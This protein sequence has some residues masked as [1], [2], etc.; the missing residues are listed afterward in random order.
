[1]KKKQSNLFNSIN[2]NVLDYILSFFKKTLIN[3]EIPKENN[4]LYYSGLIRQ[5]SRAYLHFDFAP[6]DAFGWAIENVINQLAWNV[7]M[8]T[9][10]TGGEIKI[11]DQQWQ[12]KIFDS[13]KM[14][15]N[16]GSYGFKESV[17]KNIRSISI[18]PEVGDLVL[19]NSRNFH[20]VLSASDTKRISISSF[21][22]QFSD[23]NWIAWS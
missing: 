22:G 5:I 23:G 8:Q 7:Y 18:Q 3:I 16:N 2:L 12:P 4:D 20:E 14:E 19:F 9:S 6:Y 17:V 11:Y 15:N 13:H 21:L 10:E 1:M